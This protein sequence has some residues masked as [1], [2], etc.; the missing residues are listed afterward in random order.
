[1]SN[2]SD[3]IRVS[4]FSVATDGSTD[5]EDVKLYPICIIR[6]CDP[7]DSLVKSVILSLRECNKP[8]T[9]ENI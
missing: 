3:I 7:A 4:P 8:S 6:Y 9:G 5:Y 2:T 1:M